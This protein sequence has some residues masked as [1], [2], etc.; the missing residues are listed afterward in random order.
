MKYEDSSGCRG[1]FSDPR[2]GDDAN[3]DK[4]QD[5]QQGRRDRH[6]MKFRGE[7]STGRCRR[8]GGRGYCVQEGRRRPNE[9]QHFPRKLQ[10][11]DVVPG[12]WYSFEPKAVAQ[13]D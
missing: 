11:I 4:K 6:G 7:I 10:E 13:T 5:G 12:R 2:K 3:R 8:D 1:T 9:S